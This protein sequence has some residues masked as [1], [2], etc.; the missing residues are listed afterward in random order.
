MN[1]RPIMRATLLMWLGCAFALQGVQR[2]LL[3]PLPLVSN[4]IVFAFQVAPLLAVV[5]VLIRD[6]ARGAFWAT[7]VSMLYFTLGVVQIV[8]PEERIVG[9]MEVVFSLGMFI[10][11][12]L[13]MRAEREAAPPNLNE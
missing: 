3:D 6:P 10:S 12:M 9:I 2:F 7:L 1:A 13:L 11:A 5:V 4:L 8:A